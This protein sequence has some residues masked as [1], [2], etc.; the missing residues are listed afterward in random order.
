MDHPCYK[1]GHSIEDGKPFCLQCGAPQI[2]VLMPEPAVPAVAGSVPSNVSFN[3]APG[4]DAHVFPL[5][6]P[7]PAPL[8]RPTLSGIV[9][10]RALRACAIAALI[11]IVVMLLRL[12]VPPLATLGAG[13]LAVILYRRRNPTCRV[14]ARSGAQLGAATGLLSS[15]VFAV[16]L[17]I[18][19]VVLQSGGQARQEMIEALRQVVAR[20]HDSQAQAFLDLLSNPEDLAGKLILGMVGVF[21]ISIAAGSI[22]GALTGAFLSRRNRQ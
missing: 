20:S 4:N 7:I 15:A 18:F 22:A 1:C 3:D 13:C 8:S 2:R 5:D 17:A 9:W 6:P 16:V 10:P 12:M 19:L 21:L 14:D 11:S